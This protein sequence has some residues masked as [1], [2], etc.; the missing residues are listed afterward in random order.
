MFAMVVARTVKQKRILKR[1]SIAQEL[2]CDD[3]ETEHDKNLQTRFVCPQI[4][5]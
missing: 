1:S 2:S 3:V 4:T 5:E